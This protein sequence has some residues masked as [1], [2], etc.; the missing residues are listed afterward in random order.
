MYS[1]PG[2]CTH[3][4]GYVQ[5]M[6]HL[7]SD[8][9][10]SILEHD[11][12]MPGIGIRDDGGIPARSDIGDNPAVDGQSDVVL[13]TYLAHQYSPDM[14]FLKRN[15]P[16]VKRALDYLRNTNDPDGTGTLIGSQH[17]TLDAEYFTRGAWLSLNYQAA[18]RAMAAMADEM[19][20]TSYAD[21]LRQTADKGRDYTETHLFN[22][23]YF[24]QEHDPKYPN[25]TGTFS[26]C[27]YSQLV[28]ENWSHQVGLGPIVDPAKA[29]T[30]LNS[31][32]RY[33]FT[34]DVGP[35]TK[36]Y[37]TGRPFV[38]PGEGGL[39]GC[40]WPSVNDSHNV[41]YLNECQSGYEYACSAAMIWN[42]LVDKG[43]A[44]IRT[45]HERYLAAKRNPWNEVEAGSHYSRAMASYGLFTAACGFE[46][47]GPKGYIAFLPRLSPADFRA[48]FTTAEG[49]GTFTQKRAAGRQHMSLTM[50]YGRL[51]LRSLAFA[52]AG[53]APAHVTV[54]IG[55]KPVAAASAV[56]SRRLLVTL[57]QDAHVSAG[58]SIEI[59]VV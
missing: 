8:L 37:G 12:L 9:D 41:A 28:G 48:P 2:T 15:Y 43:L 10:K 13:R 22:G 46:Y 42:G 57:A 27:E 52:L 19:G 30:A 58:Q 11:H 49:W 16:N 18:L 53:D 39:M 32:W 40:T 35:F 17:N 3:V 4:W 31:I 5:A 59:A 23:E 1:C 50:K 34:T 47:H 38:L 51:R 25:S 29:I 54:T 33:N 26:G 6:G 56:Q 14:A 44:H 7:F 55:G 20:D 24:Y 36:V 21:T 45:V